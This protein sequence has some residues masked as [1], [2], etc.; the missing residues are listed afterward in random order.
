MGGFQHQ[1]VMYREVV[2]LLAEVPD[3][4][5]VDGTVGGGGHARLLLDA[6]PGCRLLGIDRDPVAV[7]AAREALASFGDRVRIVHGNFDEVAGVVE[8]ESEGNIMGILFDLG[9]SS[10]QLDTEERGFSYWGDAPLDMRM[11]SAQ[12]LTAETVVNTYDADRL[13]EVLRT[14]GEERFARQIANAI[15]AARPLRSTSELVAAVKDAVPA[16]ARRRGGHPARR[17]FQ[18]IRMEVN[19]E[20]PNLASGLDESVHLLAPGGRILVL[21]YHSLE[22]RIVK[23]RFARWTGT[24]EQLPPGLPVEPKTTGGL[25]RV[26]TRRAVRP[27]AD[28]VAAN[29]RA[30][31]ARLRAAEKLAAARS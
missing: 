14:Y 6:R 21:A 26:L 1:P 17:T 5:I 16:P 28:E 9:V 22:D 25:V 2:E 7:A 29:P 11:D 12:E 15:V 20:L 13:T 23:E 27:R 3:G 24:S 18:A 31:S 8:R 19:H 30:R 4:L 10:P